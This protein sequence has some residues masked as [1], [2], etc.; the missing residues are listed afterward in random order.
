MDTLKYEVMTKREVISTFGFQ[1]YESL[2]I[3]DDTLLL[4]TFP[5]KKRIWYAEKD[6][7]TTEYVRRFAIGFGATFISK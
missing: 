7:P 1:Y 4:I 3:K 6:R 2:G 5:N